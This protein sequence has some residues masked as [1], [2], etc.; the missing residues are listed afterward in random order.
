MRTVTSSGW[1]SSSAP[2][3]PEESLMGLFLK[4]HS[5]V[6][7]DHRSMSSDDHF[8]SEDCLFA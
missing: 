8:D 3:Q 2:F 7:F 5:K 4:S 6:A 1:A